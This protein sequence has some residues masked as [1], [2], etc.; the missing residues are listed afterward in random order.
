MGKKTY[1]LNIHRTATPRRDRD[2]DRAIGHSRIHVRRCERERI[3]LP[4]KSCIGASSTITPS[5]AKAQI[6]PSLEYCSHI[7]GA[8]APT[9]LFILVAVQRRA[10]RLIGD[11]VLTC[12]LQTLSH[13]R[14]VL[15]V[16]SR[17][18]TDIQTNSAPPR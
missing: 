6:R 12:P 4:G 10:I 18:S 17:S 9:T 2:R 5:H 7:W 15:L 1:L 14:G 8:A 3:Q 13:R 11:Q 16:T